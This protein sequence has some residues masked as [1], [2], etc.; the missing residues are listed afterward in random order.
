MRY[1]DEGRRGPSP[2]R[3]A[4]DRLQHRQ[5]AGAAETAAA[6]TRYRVPVSNWWTTLVSP[7]QLLANLLPES[8]ESSLRELQIEKANYGFRI[9]WS[10]LP[11]CSGRQGS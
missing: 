1:Y 7:G 6:L 4:N 9:A 5:A 3:G 11:T 8:R 10:S 2:R